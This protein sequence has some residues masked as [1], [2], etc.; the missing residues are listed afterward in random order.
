MLKTEQKNFAYTDIPTNEKGFTFISML[1]M[2]S[3]IFMMIPFTAYLAKTVDF[4]SNYEQLS[5]QQF[6]LFL[7]DEMIMSTDMTI[8]STKLTFEQTDES[9]VSME[10]YNNLIV[11]RL[12]GG[13]EIYL[14]DVEDVHFTSSSYGLHASIKMMNGDQFEKNIVYYN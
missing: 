12:D 1:V 3:I 11:R 6:F 2:V 8:E 10:K 7:R 14:R 13:F 5:V 4:T 9:T